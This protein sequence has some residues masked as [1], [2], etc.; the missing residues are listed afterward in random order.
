MRACLGGC[1]VYTSFA[2]LNPSIM[3]FSLSMPLIKAITPGGPLIIAFPSA[4]GV[5]QCML[6]IFWFLG[7]F[8][9]A[10]FAFC[11]VT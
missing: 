8:G 7:R 11:L 6:P 3:L 2:K 4:K 1:G 9:F 5:Q 10:V